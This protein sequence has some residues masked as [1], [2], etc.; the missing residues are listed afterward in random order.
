MHGCSEAYH[1]YK[2][3]AVSYGTSS[4]SISSRVQEIWSH[5]ITNAYRTMK[6]GLLQ[7]LT[8]PIVTGMS[9]CLNM[10][11]STSTFAVSNGTSFV[12][13]EGRVQEIQS[14]KFTHVHQNHE[15][16]FISRAHSSISDGDVT[17]LLH[18]L[19]NFNL[20]CIQR[21]KSDVHRW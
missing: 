10:S 7:G 11:L 13:V 18:T 21:F 5:K 16:W 2:W 12:S 9:L 1:K 3:L 8:A 17:I 4:M 15:K 14:H 19:I 6:H 20:C